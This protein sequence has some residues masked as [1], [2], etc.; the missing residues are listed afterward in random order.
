MLRWNISSHIYVTRVLQ[1]HEY[2][3]LLAEYPLLSSDICMRKKKQRLSEMQLKFPFRSSSCVYDL[4][5]L[6]ASPPSPTP[7]TPPPPTAPK[8]FPLPTPPPSHH[9]H[10]HHLRLQHPTSSPCIPLPSIYYLLHHL[11]QQQ[12]YH[13]LHHHQHLT[14]DIQV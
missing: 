10:H 2:R 4:R 5:T 13:H 8:L 11:Q 12:H 9:H 14:G 1:S 3:M 7:P 6:Y